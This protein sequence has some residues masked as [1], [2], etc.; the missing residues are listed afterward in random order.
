[1]G[2]GPD[3]LIDI[4]KAMPPVMNGPGLITIIVNIMAHYDMFPKST[5]IIM[6]LVRALAELKAERP[7]FFEEGGVERSREEAIKDLPDMPPGSLH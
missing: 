2:F 5:L 1:L 3:V 7:D 4:A 6:E